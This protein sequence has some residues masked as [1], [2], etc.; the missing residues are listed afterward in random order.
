MMLLLNEPRLLILLPRS[1][2]AHTA[3]PAH[4]LGPKPGF[5]MG[6][7]CGP[8]K[9]VR[10][11]HRCFQSIFFRPVAFFFSSAL[12]P[13]VCWCAPIDSRATLYL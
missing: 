5:F 2:A 10:R 13:C 4:Y 11:G 3:S 6:D 8:R 9:D 1:F 7:V 12:V